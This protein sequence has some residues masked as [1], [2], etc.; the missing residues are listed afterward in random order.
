[1]GG[2]TFVTAKHEN[3]RMDVTYEVAYMEVINLVTE[4]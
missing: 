1:M 4:G 2:G 3:I